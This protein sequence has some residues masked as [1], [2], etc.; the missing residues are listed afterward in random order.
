MITF[1]LNAPT[2]VNYIRTQFYITSIILE[3]IFDPMFI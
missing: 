1:Y 2:Y 3:L